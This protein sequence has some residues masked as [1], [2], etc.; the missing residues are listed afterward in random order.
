MPIQSFPYQAA[1]QSRRRPLQLAAVHVPSQMMDSTTPSVHWTATPCAPRTAT[2]VALQLLGFLV[3]QKGWRFGR[4]YYNYRRSERVL[5]SSKSV[6]TEDTPFCCSYGVCPSVAWFFFISMCRDLE[7]LHL[8]RDNG[9]SC[10]YWFG[11]WLTLSP[12]VP[13]SLDEHW[14]KPK[15]PHCPQNSLQ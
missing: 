5:V 3:I 4:W 13:S 14:W 9:T 2:L 7:G 8:R 15:V 12:W 1:V 10:W 11:Y 6:A